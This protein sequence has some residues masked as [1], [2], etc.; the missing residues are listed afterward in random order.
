MA[1]KYAQIQ[2]NLW[3]D[4][5]FLDVSPPAQYLYFV[6]LSSPTMTYAGVDSWHPRRLSKR[7]RGWTVE[8]IEA[9]AAEL[10]DAHFIVVDTDTDECL[11]RTFVRND[12]FMKQPNLAVTLANDMAGIASRELRQVVTH[13]LN[14]LYEEHPDW[15]GWRKEQAMDLLKG[16]QVDAR[17]FPCG[18]PY[19]HHLA[20]VKDDDIVTPSDG[21]AALFA[22]FQDPTVNPQ[23][24]GDVYPTVDP[25]VDPTIDPKPK[26]RAKGYRKGCPTTATT[27]TTSNY[28]G[29]DVSTFRTEGA[30]VKGSPDL[31]TGGTRWGN[32]PPASTTPTT[33]PDDL[34]APLPPEPEPDHAQDDDDAP[35]S[36]QPWQP[37]TPDQWSTPDDPRCKAHANHPGDPPPCKGCKQAREWFQGSS[38]REKQARRAAI[39]ACDHCDDN[40]KRDIGPPDHPRLITCNHQPTQ[41]ETP[42]AKPMDF[43]SLVS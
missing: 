24:K 31:G 10:I 28:Q 34:D 35:D 21:G 7:S 29:K 5:D 9:A 13:E 30:S 22:S 27:T 23:V 38:K 4:D 40:G 20:E 25:Y 26:G 36:I 11:V 14:R 15:G 17:T 16:R 1:R 12:P 43:L 8:A 3:M 18:N 33:R 42:P 32:T 19:A 2:F 37:T 6:L 41:Q 39:T